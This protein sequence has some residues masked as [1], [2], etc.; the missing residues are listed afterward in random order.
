MIDLFV[1]AAVSADEVL[2]FPKGV[3][4]IILIK[5]FPLQVNCKEKRKL[6]FL[7]YNHERLDLK[8]GI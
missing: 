5:Y 1:N 6:I 4:K 2:Y 7:Q 8:I 3:K